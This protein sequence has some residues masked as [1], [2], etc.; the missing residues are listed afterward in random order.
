MLTVQNGIL[1]QAQSA[2]TRTGEA[3]VIEQAKLDILVKQTEEKV[4]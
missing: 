1:T 4:E 2:K 3:S